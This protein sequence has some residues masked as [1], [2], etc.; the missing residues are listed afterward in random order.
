M[1]R[2]LSAPKLVTVGAA[3]S[4][5]DKLVGLMIGRLGWKLL[6]DISKDDL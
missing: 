3:K 6:A 1:V 5:L 2:L 4:L